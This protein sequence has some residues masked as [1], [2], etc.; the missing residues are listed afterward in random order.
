[1]ARERSM[2]GGDLVIHDR[3]ARTFVVHGDEIPATLGG[4]AE[5]NIANALA[6][7]TAGHALGASPQTIADALKAFTSSHTENPGRF[8]VHDAHGFRVIVDYAHNPGAMRAI[9][10][11]VERLRPTPSG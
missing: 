11:L 4:L 5:F 9:G 1:V 8:N 7:I 3:G 10:D 2:R 6:A